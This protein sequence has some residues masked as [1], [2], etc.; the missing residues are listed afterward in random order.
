MLRFLADGSFREENATPKQLG[1]GPR[2]VSLFVASSK[3]SSTQRATITPR[4]GCILIRTEMVRGIV[5]Q[6]E[7]IVFPSR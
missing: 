7:A 3:A 4:E 2:D 6:H 1:L 5:R